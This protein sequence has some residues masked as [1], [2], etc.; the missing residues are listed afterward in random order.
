MYEPAA[1]LKFCNSNETRSTSVSADEHQ[2]HYWRE[3]SSDE[4]TWSRL[5][6]VSDKS[7][8]ALM[9]FK[10]WRP[11]DLPCVSSDGLQVSPR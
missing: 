8:L 9:N 2:H 10:S 4:Y 3:V 11:A 5:L 6:S 7:V 1:C